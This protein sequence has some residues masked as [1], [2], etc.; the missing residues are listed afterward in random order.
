M[1]SL[2]NFAH[3]HF[4]IWLNGSQFEWVELEVHF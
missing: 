1:R 2:V 3:L 4:L